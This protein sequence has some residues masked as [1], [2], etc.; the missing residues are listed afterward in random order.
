MYHST[1]GVTY[2]K[3]INIFIAMS[4]IFMK[5]NTQETGLQVVYLGCDVISFKYIT[6]LEQECSCSYPL[7]LNP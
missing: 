1:V 6:I 2:F 4:T 5:C 3:Q 7:V